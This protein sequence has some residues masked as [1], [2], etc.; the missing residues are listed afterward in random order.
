M[1]EVP[2]SGSRTTSTMKMESTLEQP[3]QVGRGD[4]GRSRHLAS[5]H[6]LLQAFAVQPHLHRAQAALVERIHWQ[7][8]WSAEPEI[9][10]SATARPRLHIGI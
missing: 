4:L 7:R 2:T 1:R 8:Y 9:A 10:S 3:C 6:G 5:R